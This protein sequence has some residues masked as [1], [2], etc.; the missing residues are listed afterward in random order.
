MSKAIVIDADFSANSFDHVSFNIIH[1]T[2]IAVTPST[3]SM[4]AIGATSKLP[5]PMR[6][7]SPTASTA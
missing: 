3:L 1:A 5:P 4:S 6:R 2:G 7:S